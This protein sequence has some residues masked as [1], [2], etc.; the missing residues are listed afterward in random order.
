MKELCMELEMELILYQTPPLFL[1]VLFCSNLTI[2][3]S[4]FRD[5]HIMRTLID[6]N[7]RDH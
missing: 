3:D 4:K 7:F 5:I 2:K 1:E 6:A